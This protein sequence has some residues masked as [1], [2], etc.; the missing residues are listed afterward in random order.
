ME[1]TQGLRILVI[2]D[3]AVISLLIEADLGEAGYNVVDV[4]HNASKAL[5]SIQKHKPN[6]VIIDID[7]GGD[8]DG[9]DIGLKLNTDYSIPFIYLTAFSDRS[10]LDRAK[11]TEPCGYIVKPYKP[12]D[13]YAAITIGMFN[14][15]NRKSQRLLT[16]ES[17]NEL[18]PDPLTLRE[19]DIVKE[20]ASGLTNAQV[21]ANQHLALNT[22]KW[23]LQNVYSKLGV[24]NRTSLVKLVFEGLDKKY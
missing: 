11:K 17:V 22:I 15:D 20:I 4:V 2:E 12:N 5:A 1:K 16:F 9:I 3:D 21:A 14:F 23:H 8:I 19:F 10:T 13:L 24:K 7:L 18:S 6:L